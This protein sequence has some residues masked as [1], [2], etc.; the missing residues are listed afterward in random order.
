MWTILKWAILLGLVIGPFVLSYLF[1]ASI[2]GRKVALKQ[3]AIFV[4][5]YIVVVLGIYGLSRWIPALWMDNIWI[6]FYL[7]SSV[8]SWVLVFVYPSRRRKA[9]KVLLDVGTNA[10]N[11]MSL[12]FGLMLVIF[13]FQS[14]EDLINTNFSLGEVSRSIFRLSWGALL[15]RS[16]FSG[17]QITDKGILRFAHLMNWERINSY[18]WEEENE[19]T[20]TLNINRRFPFLGEVSLP[21]PSQHRESVDRLLIQ[22]VSVSPS[23]AK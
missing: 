23:D 6:V 9:G 10:S 15:I 21:I 20:L 2:L 8:I 14:I 1:A 5:F 22:H 16:G 7:A 3:I 18:R 13:T 17:L 11:G 12:V 4:P 19:N